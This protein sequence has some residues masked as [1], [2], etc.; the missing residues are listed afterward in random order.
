MSSVSCSSISSIS[1][2]GSTTKDQSKAPFRKP[3]FSNVS[4]IKTNKVRT[5]PNSPSLRA[6]PSTSG[7]TSAREPANQQKKLGGN[8]R[9]RSDSITGTMAARPA[10]QSNVGSNRTKLQESLTKTNDCKT[11]TSNTRTKSLTTTMTNRPQGK[12][13]QR[14]PEPVGQDGHGEL[15]SI[16]VT[17][18]NAQQPGVKEEERSLEKKTTTAEVT[19]MSPALIRR[20]FGDTATSTAAPVPADKA[21]GSTSEQEDHTVVSVA[22][23]T[24]TKSYHPFHAPVVAVAQ[25]MAT[26]TFFDPQDDVSVSSLTEDRNEDEA[27]EEAGP[28]SPLASH[29]MNFSRPSSRASSVMSISAHEAM[30]RIM[31]QQGSRRRSFGGRVAELLISSQQSSPRRMS[32]SAY[33]ISEGV[34]PAQIRVSSIESFPDHDLPPANEK[35]QFF[36]GLFKGSFL[37]SSTTAKAEVVTNNA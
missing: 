18:Q 32:R 12:E 36:K 19:S 16:V 35:L 15:D 23:A 27:A 14:G 33:S 3:D 4:G 11:P 2:N 5:A 34:G 17:D 25:D 28:S 13:V 24:E 6:V 20:L 26:A 37:G 7:E 31:E 8:T 30:S 21:S 10:I 1:S 9:G 22:V 29:P